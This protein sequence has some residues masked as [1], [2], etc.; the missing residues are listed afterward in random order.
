[1]A[2]ITTKEK[3]SQ[4]TWMDCK[5]MY[6]SKKNQSDGKVY[7]SNPITNRKVLETAAT[8]K[9]LHKQ[10]EKI[11]EKLENE[12]TY[13]KW[14]QSPY[15]D[16]T[17][18][19]H[20][21]LD[22][23]LNI[24][25]TYNTYAKIYQSA[26]KFYEKKGLA[27]QQIQE[28][29]PKVHYLFGEIDFLYMNMNKED[30]EED[31]LNFIDMVVASMYKSDAENMDITK[32]FNPVLQ[33]ILTV[34]EGFSY[35]EKMFLGNLIIEL[36]YEIFVIYKKFINNL[37]T[38]SYDSTRFLTIKNGFEYNLKILKEF[39]KFITRFNLD[40]IA[41]Q[42][43]KSEYVSNAGHGYKRIT[44]YIY[45]KFT[46]RQQE[47]ILSQFQKFIKSY[48]LIQGIDKHIEY[49]TELYNIFN[50]KEAPHLSPFENLENKQFKE[51]EDPFISIL[52]EFKDLD[53][54]KMSLPKRMFNDSQY[55]SFEKKYKSL[56]EKFKTAKETWNKSDKSE[57]PP[58]RPSV[59]LPNG[60]NLFIGQPLPKHIPDAEYSKIVES[61]EKKK[62]LLDQYKQLI[63]IGFIQLARDK[64]GRIINPSEYELL[65][66]D[67]EYLE[68][69]V[70]YNGDEDKQ[71]CNGPL[72]IISQ[73]EFSDPNYFLSKLQLMYKLQ[74]K[75]ENGEVIATY[76]FYAPNLYNHIVSQ[77]NKKETL[78][79]P[80]DPSHY[81]T[82]TDVDGL[83]KIMKI[84]D[85]NIER[86]VFLK[87]IHD[88]LLELTYKEEEYKGHKYFIVY[89]VRK[90]CDIEYRLKK[91]CTILADV[92]SDETNDNSATST[93]FL[94]SI[95]KLFNQGKLLETYM[96]PYQIDGHYIKLHIHFNN[97]YNKELWDKKREDQVKMLQFYLEEINKYL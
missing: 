37:W 34:R 43:Y 22:V 74:K 61:F 84:I 24:N 56:D 47:E 10:C 26:Y 50:W 52:E 6:D 42:I 86:P 48:N 7:Y 89:L 70:L 67:R 45:E 66:K 31:F 91:I 96:P 69:N 11:K 73:D 94:F 30:F 68:N 15:I 80:A 19:N 79:N 21:P 49:Y 95:F 25:Y 27:K 3:I 20:V 39:K 29:L 97:Y 23:S 57:A 28:K 59:K 33:S 76:C 44:E 63:D 87:P 92:D 75:K 4:L 16:P 77:V 54:N 82:D 38:Y 65:D 90:V 93:V 40:R 72:D 78:R 9:E 55:Q 62:P 32:F 81:I 64:Q 58:T 13:V 88:K 41:E 5:L 85:P 46:Q 1:M 60:Q 83:M 51:I 2:S 14:L 8:F 12:E 53:L 17:S 71:K 35:L 18:D 36:Y